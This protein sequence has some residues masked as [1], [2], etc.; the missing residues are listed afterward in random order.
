MESENKHPLSYVTCMMHTRSERRTWSV[1]GPAICG[2][3]YSVRLG[4]GTLDDDDY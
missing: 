2:M 4:Y 3:F 1:H